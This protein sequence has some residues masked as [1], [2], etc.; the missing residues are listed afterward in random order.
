MRGFSLAVVVGVEGVSGGVSVWA[1][2]DWSSLIAL[3]LSGATGA[4]E[5]RRV[6]TGVEAVDDIVTVK[7]IDVV[8]EKLFKL[9]SPIITF[10]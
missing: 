1:E 10:F 9:A 7:K 6:R 3:T 4:P 5:S 2:G 8:A